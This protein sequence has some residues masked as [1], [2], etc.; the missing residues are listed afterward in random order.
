MCE[1]AAQFLYSQI[2]RR[3]VCINRKDIIGI[4]NKQKLLGKRGECASFLVAAHLKK[5]NLVIAKDRIW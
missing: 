1:T 3:S 5:Q 2:K 4:S